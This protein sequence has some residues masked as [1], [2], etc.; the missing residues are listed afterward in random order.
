MHQHLW[1]TSRS[2]IILMQE[3]VLPCMSLPSFV[4]LVLPC[5]QPSLHGPT[6][7]S[8]LLPCFALGLSLGTFSSTSTF[9]LGFSFMGTTSLCLSFSHPEASFGLL[10]QWFTCTNM[11]SLGLILCLG[12]CILLAA[13]YTNSAYASAFLGSHAAAFEPLLTGLLGVDSLIPSGIP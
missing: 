8:L 13:W 6:S 3:N 11:S 9:R 12:R 1:F 5:P 7:S 2:I 10:I 4:F